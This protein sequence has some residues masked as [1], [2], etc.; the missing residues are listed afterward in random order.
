VQPIASNLGN[1]V[2]EDTQSQHIAETAALYA[3]SAVI[4]RVPDS[5]RQDLAE[6]IKKGEPVQQA[7]ATWIQ[8]QFAS[9][10]QTA[11]D[12]TEAFER[13]INDIVGQLAQ[14]PTMEEDLRLLSTY[15]TTHA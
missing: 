2:L 5:D 9:N 8:H 12:L 4:D 11:I 14:T 6:R 13:A 1:S 10:P 7:I 15:H 3:L